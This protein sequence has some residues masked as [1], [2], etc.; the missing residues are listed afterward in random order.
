MASASKIEQ[1]TCE[2]NDLI[3]CNEQVSEET[4][5]W[6]VDLTRQLIDEQ[7]ESLREQVKKLE[8]Q[9]AYVR[10]QESGINIVPS[11]MQKVAQLFKRLTRSVKIHTFS[12]GHDDPSVWLDAYVQACAYGGIESDRDLI[13]QLGQHLNEEARSW[14][15]QRYARHCNDSWQDWKTDF[16]LIWDDFKSETDQDCFTFRYQFG[17]LISYYLE[18][19]R[20]IHLIFPNMS[21][22]HIGAL[23]ILGLPCAMRQKIERCDLS[24]SRNIVRA[25]RRLRPIVSLDDAASCASHPSKRV[26]RTNQTSNPEHLSNDEETSYD[27]SSSDSDATSN[28]GDES[29]KLYNQLLDRVSRPEETWTPESSPPHTPTRCLPKQINS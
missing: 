4:S 5:G 18:K 28:P 8:D 10:A 22:K 14:F 16:L 24:N 13:S 23:V 21:D 7:L 20:R 9:V 6:V 26:K 12:P 29:L 25:L 19:V 2:S 17:S 27:E 15:D 3:S 11:L 1:A